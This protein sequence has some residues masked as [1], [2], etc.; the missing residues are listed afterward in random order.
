MA[1]VILSNLS[2][3]A[4]TSVFGEV[5]LKVVLLSRASSSEWASYAARASCFSNTYSYLF[6]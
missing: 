1:S 4:V 6:T 3:Q 5:A 2:N